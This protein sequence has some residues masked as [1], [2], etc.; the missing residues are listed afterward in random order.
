[1]DMIESAIGLDTN[2]RHTE[3]LG[4]KN[5]VINCRLEKCMSSGSVCSCCFPLTLPFLPLEPLPE[6]YFG[7][8]IPAPRV[9]GAKS[10]L[11]V[12]FRSFFA[13]DK[14][15]ILNAS[16]FSRLGLEAAVASAMSAKQKSAMASKMDTEI[17][18]GIRT[19][20]YGLA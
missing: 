18:K 7:R 11:P 9:T 2:G 5:S 1:M 17:G 12:S 3:N 19:F 20:P 8:V 15:S 16:F 4:F 10:S 6:V 14:K 13:G